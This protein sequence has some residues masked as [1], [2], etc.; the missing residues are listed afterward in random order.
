MASQ[1]YKMPHM[2]SF[3][4]YTTKERDSIILAR[5]RKRWTITFYAICYFVKYAFNFSYYIQIIERD[6][7]IH[8]N[9]DRERRHHCQLHITP[10]LSLQGNRKRQNTIYLHYDTSFGV[11]FRPRRKRSGVCWKRWGCWGCLG[12]WGFYGFWIQGFRVRDRYWEG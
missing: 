1:F 12:C 11:A 9:A 6:G 2:P 7:N 5:E 3:S 8:I 4:N 10:S